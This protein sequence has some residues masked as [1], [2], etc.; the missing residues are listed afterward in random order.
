MEPNR[1]LLSC[2]NHL[3]RASRLR[4]HGARRLQPS[5]RTS[6]EGDG[7]RFGA[8]SGLNCAGGKRW[9]GSRVGHTFSTSAGRSMSGPS[10]GAAN[11]PGRHFQLTYFVDWCSFVAF[12]SALAKLSTFLSTTNVATAFRESTCPLFK[13]F[14][15]QLRCFHF[16]Q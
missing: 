7:V 11:D 6:A 4:T 15:G 5:A 1:C 12:T 2:F 10:P 8:R 13:R 16:S 14:F 9:I 3:Q